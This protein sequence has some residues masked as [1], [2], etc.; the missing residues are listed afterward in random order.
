MEPVDGHDPHPHLVA[1]L[2]P[3]PRQQ[4]R[5]RLPDHQVILISRPWL[6]V[7]SSFLFLHNSLLFDFV[8]LFYPEK[9]RKI[10]FFPRNKLSCALANWHPADRSAKM[11]L[12]PWKEVFTRG[13]MQAFLLKNI[14]PKLEAALL[15]L[16]IN[17]IN[18]VNIIFLDIT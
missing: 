13:A 10:L 15:H 3:A 6:V 1:P 12:L 8:F 9:L 7:H 14:V 5:H 2:A 18:Q 11:I 16:Q 17:P 4:T